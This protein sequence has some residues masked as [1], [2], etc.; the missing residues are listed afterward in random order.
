MAKMYPQH[1]DPKTA[2]HAERDLFET[3]RTA[4][5]NDYFVFHSACFQLPTRMGNVRDGEADFLVVHPQKGVLVIEVKGGEIIHHRKSGEWIS[6]DRGGQR[7]VIKDPL[8]Q[9]KTALYCF[10]DLW[11]LVTRNAKMPIF[12]HA[13]AF[14]DTTVPANADL[15]PDMRRALVMDKADA[16]RPS[17][18]LDAA[19]A[20]YLGTA[21]ESMFNAD[22]KHVQAFLKQFG[23]TR[24]LR[25]AMW[26][27]IQHEKNEMAELTEQQFL[28]LDMLGRRR[29]AVVSGCAG[30]GK[31]ML[32]VEKASRLAEAG[33]R[34]LLTCYNKS[35]ASFLRH[36]L[37]EVEGLTVTHFHEL[38]HD[39]AKTA[40]TL[41][42]TPDYGSG[43]F[44]D[45]ILPEAFASAI[46]RLPDT[47]FDA[48]VVDEA[49]DFSDTWW[50]PLTELLNDPEND[51]FYV[52]YDRQQQLYGKELNLP[53]DDEPFMLSRNCRN[54]EPIHRVVMRFGGEWTDLARSSGASG[55]PVEVC[56]YAPEDDLATLA[57]EWVEKIVDQEQVPVERIVLLSPYARS[58][59]KSL[60]SKQEKI[61]RFRLTESDEPAPDELRFSTVHGFKG[62]ESDVIVLVEADRWRAG[63][64]RDALLYVACSRARHHLVVLLPEG[65][66]GGLRQALTGGGR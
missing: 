65:K 36:R 44:Y 28:A 29:R 14:P 15:G 59:G 19:Y 42:E 66:A 31:T 18:W 35:L 45:E 2:S 1:F 25:P 62:C 58:S 11:D 5:P 13:V 12:G 51:S 57:G 60:L 22:I 55:R 61:G 56:P 30:S 17:E 7:H 46:D 38:A 43:R 41:P 32:A 48:L 54:T 64:S 16:A 47:R 50:V 27:D 4:L 8:N 9:A 21:D 37:G 39:L 6:I 23:G 40:G 52:F 33:H 3:F 20:Y 34:V 24:R 26:G 10:K 49:Q 63:S 53:I